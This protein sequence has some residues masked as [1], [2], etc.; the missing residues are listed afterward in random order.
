MKSLTLPVILLLV[1]PLCGGLYF[2]YLAYEDWRNLE[3]FESKAVTVDGEVEGY[4]SY[5][6]ETQDEDGNVSVYTVYHPVIR[7]TYQDSI[8][9]EH[10]H[11][12]S[13]SKDYQI[14]EVVSL[15]IDPELPKQYRINS[16]SGKW[17]TIANN[18]IGGL[19]GLLVGA[20]F[21]WRQ[22]MY[23]FFRKYS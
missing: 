10:M 21:F 15:L 11:Y 1:I 12:S 8:Y 7:Y 5:Q 18:A 4:M 3:A 6:R 14:N 19:A 22:G 9:T 23:R 17:S 2:F 13:T 20:Y 16:Y